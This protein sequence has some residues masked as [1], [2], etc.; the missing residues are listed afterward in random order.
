MDLKLYI[1]GKT[2]T[3]NIVIKDFNR[4]KES[5]F[6]EDKKF[7]GQ[8][9]EIFNKHKK[10]IESFSPETSEST[11]EKNIFALVHYVQYVFKT[12]KDYMVEM[13]V[14]RE[15]INYE[16]LKKDISHLLYVGNIIKY[17]E[18]IKIS[19]QLQFSETQLDEL[20][21]K[22]PDSIELYII[23][24]NRLGYSSKEKIRPIMDKFLSSISDSNNPSVNKDYLFLYT[25]T[26]DGDWI[27]LKNKSK[28][29]IINK[30]IQN[31]SKFDYKGIVDK[32]YILKNNLNFKPNT[33]LNPELIDKFKVLKNTNAKTDNIG[34]VAKGKDMYETYDEQLYRKVIPFDGTSL[35]DAKPDETIMKYN[36]MFEN[37]L[38]EHFIPTKRVL[39]PNYDDMNALKKRAMENINNYI[40]N[41]YKKSNHNTIL[42]CSDIIDIISSTFLEYGYVDGNP[43]YELQTAQFTTIR[44]LIKSYTKFMKYRHKTK[45]DNDQ[46]NINYY[47]GLV[48]GYFKKTI[49]FEVQIFKEFP[50]KREIYNSYIKKIINI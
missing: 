24:L 19:K 31:S 18:L 12:L 23:V 11:D 13:K 39:L 36:R 40:T 33:A 8:N 26:P 34:I 15:F 22:Y 30:V 21:K 50:Y 38:M 41:K 47:K 20:C 6:D 48:E 32:D 49:N 3:L 44:E 42:I 10:P 2:K 43:I 28:C 37:K 27:K 46:E 25:L 29:T 1:I 7:I 16:K 35:E 4:I 9:V 17:C 5:I 45:H 14:Y